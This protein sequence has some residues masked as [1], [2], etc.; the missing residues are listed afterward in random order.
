MH[1][2]KA[3]GIGPAGNGQDETPQHAQGLRAE[4]ERLRE[5]LARAE[6]ECDTLHER[7]ERQVKGHL[8]LEERVQAF[9]EEDRR[10]AREYLSIAQQNASLANLYVAGHRLHSGLAREEV[11]E[12]IKEIIATLVG[13]EEMALFE[14]DEKAPVLSLADGVGIDPVAFRA[15]AIGAGI[16]GRTAAKGETYIAGRDAVEEPAPGEEALTACIPLIDY[17]IFDLLARQASMA[18]YCTRLH[19][20]R[21]ASSGSGA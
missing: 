3:E 8:E 4:N 5:R 15:V 10:V 21:L 6:V 7:I 13:S 2:S 11:V 1:E 17:E 9:E 20:A 12:A 18:L 19:A 14:R 16:I